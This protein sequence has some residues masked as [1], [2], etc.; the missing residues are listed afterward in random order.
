MRGRLA[1][2]GDGVGGV[3]GVSAL[4]EH[5]EGH[6]RVVVGL[7]FVVDRQ[8]GRLVGAGRGLE[9]GLS[10]RHLP[11]IGL[12][13]ALLVDDLEGHALL[14]DRH[15]CGDARGAGDHRASI[16]E[17]AG[18]RLAGEAEDDGQ[19]GGDLGEGLDHC[20]A[21]GLSSAAL[22]SVC[23]GRRVSLFVSLV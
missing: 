13:E 22:R 10:G 15:R 9:A 18:F 2:A 17:E 16:R 11:H 5:G 21:P 3:D 8:P 7:G 4:E 23:L 6:R 20:L 12:G 1:E 14:G 19:G